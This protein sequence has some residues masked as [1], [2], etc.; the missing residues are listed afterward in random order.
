MKGLLISFE[1]TSL[2]VLPRGLQTS[3]KALLKSLDRFNNPKS[4]SVTAE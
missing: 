1:G 2:S 4:D 3:L